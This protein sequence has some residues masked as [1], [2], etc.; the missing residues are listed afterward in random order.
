MPRRP[1]LLSA[2]CILGSLASLYA[3]LL[4]LSPGLWAVRPSSGQRAAGA[5]A[6]AV[7]LASLYG[8]WRMRRWGVMVLGAALAVRIVYGVAAGLPWSWAGLAGPVGVLAVGLAYVRRM[9]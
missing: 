2:V 9:S 4:L 5:V 7:A 6:L 3:L 8:L 1:Y